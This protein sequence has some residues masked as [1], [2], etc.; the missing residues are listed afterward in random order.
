MTIEYGVLWDRD[1][2]VVV[3]RLDALPADTFE[4]SLGRQGGQ[5]NAYER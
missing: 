5:E 1:A 2:D 3:E 4:R